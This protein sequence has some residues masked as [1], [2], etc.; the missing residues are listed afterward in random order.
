MLTINGQSVYLGQ[1]VKTGMQS[2]CEPSIIKRI[3]TENE[4]V[5]VVPVTGGQGGWYSVSTIKSVN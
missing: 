4:A 2:A 1:R 5:F 3:D